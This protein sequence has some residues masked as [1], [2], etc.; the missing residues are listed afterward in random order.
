MHIM[1]D[2]K[3]YFSWHIWLPLKLTKKKKMYVFLYRI[4]L[5]ITNVHIKFRKWFRRK[6]LIH[7]FTCT[8]FCFLQEDKKGAEAIFFMYVMFNVSENKF[9]FLKRHEE[10]HKAMKWQRVTPKNVH[11]KWYLM[12]IMNISGWVYIYDVHLLVE[13]K[14]KER[15]FLIEFL[16]I[17]RECIMLWIS[18]QQNNA[19]NTAFHE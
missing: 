15:N 12:V 7:T 10:S 18:K 16:F 6:I 5:Y 9:S 2:D 13:H 19:Q 8:A 11:H 3:T 1:F 14:D 4:I 17:W